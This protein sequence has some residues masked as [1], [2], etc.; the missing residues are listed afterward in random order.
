MQGVFCCAIDLNFRLTESWGKSKRDSKGEV[1]C[2]SSSGRALKIVGGLRLIRPV[3]PC[4]RMIHNQYKFLGVIRNLCKLRGKNSFN[5]GI[6]FWR[7]TE[8]SFITK[9]LAADGLRSLVTL[10]LHDKSRYD[11]ILKINETA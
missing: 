3:V 9:I 4:R 1:A 11:L 6:F 7:E 5:K 2:L 8:I 10:T